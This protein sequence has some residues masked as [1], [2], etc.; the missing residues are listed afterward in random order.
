[1]TSYPIAKARSKLAEIINKVAYGGE[2]IAISKHGK[3]AV[4]I[5]PLDDLNFLEAIEDRIDIKEALE[6]LEDPARIPW[7]RVKEELGL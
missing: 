5:V 3:T 2:R 1:M 4:A 6:A 7:D